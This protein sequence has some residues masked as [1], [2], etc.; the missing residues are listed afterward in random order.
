VVPSDHRVSGHDRGPR[1]RHQGS[2]L[3]GARR[4]IAGIVLCSIFLTVTA[5]NSALG[6]YLKATGRI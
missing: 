5:I 2:A 3:R 6:A 1:V 4:A